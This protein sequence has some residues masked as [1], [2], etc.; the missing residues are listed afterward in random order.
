M[1]ILKPEFITV[2]VT[3]IYELLVFIF[4]SSDIVH[5]G[6]L[7]VLFLMADGDNVSLTFHSQYLYTIHTSISSYKT[8]FMNF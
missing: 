6:L 2:F 4:T 3:D 5:V 7:Y 8:F 1:F